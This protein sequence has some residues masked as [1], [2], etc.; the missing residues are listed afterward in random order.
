[1][2]PGKSSI[3]IVADTNILISAFIFPEGL[4]YEIIENILIGQ[5]KLGISSEILQ[6]FAR[7]L[8]LK[9]S[10]PDN[11]IE[12]LITFIKRNAEIVAP[13]KKISIIKDEADNRILECAETF[14]AD[15]IIS[16]DNHI[17]R[18][19]R[20]K[21]IRIIKPSEFLKLTLK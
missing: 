10:Y 19:K 12:G 11:Q 7:V 2:K 6:E 4:I 13:E 15:Y 8:K 16:G 17:L 20:Y 1:M 9:F 3:K 18:L 14:K 21:K 5:Y